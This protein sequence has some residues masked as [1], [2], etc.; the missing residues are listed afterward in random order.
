MTTYLHRLY[1]KAVASPVRLR[2]LPEIDAAP[3]VTVDWSEEILDLAPSPR[4]LTWHRTDGGYILDAPASGIVVE[5]D[6]TGSRLTVHPNAREVDLADFGYPSLPSVVR[7]TQRL[8]AD[9]LVTNALTA[10]PVLWGRVALHS[11]TLSADSGVVMLCGRSGW[12]KSTLSQHLRLSGMELLDDDSASVQISGDGLVV[13]PMGARAR[14]RQDAA[15]G[16]GVRGETLPGYADGKQ[17]LTSVPQVAA[18]EQIA[19]TFHLV[20]LPRDSEREPLVVKRL[21]PAQ[22]LVTASRSMYVLDRDDEPAREVRFR[23]AAQLAQFPAYSVVYCRDEV[24]P[25][26]VAAAIVAAVS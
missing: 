11:A 21:D 1:D 24:R 2:L 22:A 26:Q 6:A 16:L 9:T 19:A 10:L 7:G 8:A 14:V 5:V 25:A 12:G 3:D 23:T 18:H 15:E 13:V 17:A 4:L 20:Q